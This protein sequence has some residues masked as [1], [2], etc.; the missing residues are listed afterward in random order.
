[1]RQ[2]EASRSPFRTVVCI[3]TKS[4]NMK[5]NSAKELI[6]PGL[7][8]SESKIT[9][10][11]QKLKFFFG[12]FFLAAKL[13]FLQILNLN[14]KLNISLKIAELQCDAFLKW[15]ICHFQMVYFVLKN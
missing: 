7:K 14:F 3:S 2:N 12:S 13:Q 4:P 8:M 9:F 6:F 10:L 11:L 1:M 5:P 15:F